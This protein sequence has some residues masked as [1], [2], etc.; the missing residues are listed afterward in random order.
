MK[1]KEKTREK[2]IASAARVDISSSP[3][4]AT[5]TFPAI[6]A[7]GDVASRGCEKA[8]LE[9]A[10]DGRRATLR[11]AKSARSKRRPW[12]EKRMLDERVIWIFK[13][14]FSCSEASCLILPDHSFPRG[15]DSQAEYA[16]TK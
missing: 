6:F 11:D 15:P 14:A 8:L 1:R 10:Y 3:R 7:D 2:P 9:R 13:N 12:I 16:L 4:R 5:K